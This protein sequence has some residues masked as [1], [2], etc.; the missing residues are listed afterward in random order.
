MPYN[1][2]G[3]WY[4][5]P[6][7]RKNA[8]TTQYADKDL[9]ELIPLAQQQGIGIPNA[10]PKMGLF[11]RLMN[12]LRIGETGP[13][14]QAT[15][16]GGSFL[17]EYAK[18]IGQTVSSTFTGKPYSPP[19][20]KDVLQ[21][22]LGQKQTGLP[23]K[24]LETTSGL[25]GDILG[26]PLTY[27]TLGTTGALKL[28]GKV[29]SN[30]AKPLL[31]KTA[32]EFA[33]RAGTK[34]TPEIMQAARTQWAEGL[35]QGLPEYTRHIDPGG[36]KFAGASIV[37]GETI[38]RPFKKPL[39]ILG[40][41]SIQETIKKQ[42]I[43]EAIGKTFN[44]DYGL[45]DPHVA[46]KQ[47]H[48]DEVTY[49][50]SKDF[51]QWL[52]LIKPVKA[53]DR[54]NL[55]QAIERNAI[56]SL[57][58]ELQKKAQEIR[59]FLDGFKAR[60]IQSGILKE[61]LP[62]YVPHVYK[63][64]D[65]DLILSR[66]PDRTTSSFT[67]GKPRLIGTLEEAESLGLKPEMD[68]AK[69]VG[70]YIQKFNRAESNARYLRDLGDNLGVQSTK[71]VTE[72][73][74]K[75]VDQQVLDVDQNTATHISEIYKNTQK[76]AE[77]DTELAGVQ[78][79]QRIMTGYGADREVRGFASSFPDWLPEGAR[80]KPIVDKI[81][82]HLMNGTFPSARAGNVRAGY[83]AAAKQLLSEEVPQGMRKFS[84]L[85]IAP[86][87]KIAKVDQVLEQAKQ[88]PFT[89]EE[90]AKLEA[91][92]SE[93]LVPYHDDVIGDVLLPQSVVADLTKNPRLIEDEGVRTL[94]KGYDKALN[95]WK[96]SVTSLF[97]AFHVRNASS[98]VLQN[99]LDIG[100]DA[101][102]PE[103]HSV[104]IA[105]MRM[106]DD[107][108][109]SKE[110]QALSDLGIKPPVEP[111]VLGP[112]AQTLRGTKG[113]TA[114]DIMKTHPNIKLKKDVPAKDIYGNKVVIPDGEKLT[115]YELKGNK[116]LLQDGETYIVSK[117]QFQNIKGQSVGGEPKP[118]APEL[119]GLEE[120][121]R[122]GTPTVDY[123]TY[124]NEITD[125]NQK[126]TG[127]FSGIND[128]KNS[129]KL[130]DEQLTKLKQLKEGYKTAEPKY[131]QYQLP[132]GKNYKEVLI[133]APTR[134]NSPYV[135]VKKQLGGGDYE[136]G[137]FPNNLE[138]RNEMLKLPANEYYIQPKNASADFKSSHWDEPNVISHLR[139]NERTYKGKKVTFM[140]ELQ[141]DWAREARKGQA[142]DARFPNDPYTQAHQSVPSNPLL[143]NWQ[144]PTIKRAL[145]DAVDSDAQYF[146]W[147]NGEQTSARYDLATHL[148]L[149]HWIELPGVEG[150]KG[151]LISLVEKNGE[152]IDMVITK[153]GTIAKN[154][155]KNVPEGW[156]GKKLDEVIGKGLADSIMA[157]ETGKLSG[158]GLK[159]GG[160]W[161]DNLYNKQVKN[162][163]E[164]LT[165]GKV[166]VL[167]MGLPIEKVSKEWR[168]VKTGKAPYT[169]EKLTP[170]NIK[171][172]TEVHSTI[173]SGDSY[174]ITDILGDGEF[175]AVPKD[176]AETETKYLS[177]GW[178]R[179]SKIEHA[180]QTFDISTKT[181][182][183]QGIKITPKIRA[184]VLGEALE[185][186]TSGK[187]FDE[188]PQTPKLPPELEPVLGKK[189]VEKTGQYLTTD[190]GEQIP[191]SL[192]REEAGKRQIL[193]GNF[194]I[195]DAAQTIDDQLL[196]GLRGTGKRALGLPFRAGRAVGGTIEDEARM[197]NFISNIQKGM[198]FEQAAKQTKKFLFDYQNLS[199]FEKEVMRRLVPFYT[200]VRKNISLQLEMLATRPGKV[201][202]EVKAIRNI[203]EP[204]T[205]EEKLEQLPPWAAA[206][207]GAK[208]GTDKYGRPLYMTGTGLPIEAA[209]KLGLKDLLSML[210]PAIKAPMELATGRD[211]FRGKDI[212]DV[213]KADEVAEIVN[214]TSKA[215]GVDEQE[216]RDALGITSEVKDVY[217]NNKKT[218]DK[219]T[220]YAMNPTILYL[221]RQ[222]P[223]SRLMGTVGYAAEPDVS[224]QQKLLKLLTGVKAYSFDEDEQNYFK[225]LDIKDDLQSLLKRK[226][227]IGTGTYQYEK[228]QQQ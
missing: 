195:R 1:A 80:T 172:G 135:L 109:V 206:Q 194:F 51:N 224:M 68:I 29:L 150:T 117:S 142:T 146:A 126:N 106:S 49:N 149:V 22:V 37:P 216:A 144:E 138:A 129:G 132:D 111:V 57:T 55:S 181:T 227:L 77:L 115:P 27:L 213:Y 130:T 94:L 179:E 134:E 79:G 9:R 218:G 81:K 43:V 212:K 34:I 101:I 191:Y 112:I 25:A 152:E 100:L 102:N 160:E 183:Q 63:N 62:E 221:L 141:S 180:K 90:I 98:N 61:G 71:E 6:N 85:G 163:V 228:K 139:L 41:K 3:Q 74:V 23:G 131:S 58:P 197:V 214:M 185:I 198:D 169:F 159:F 167:D 17:P 76:G 13:A 86:A 122:G 120:S 60:G 220:V 39:D 118:F 47:K 14:L 53:V 140:E 170:Q 186:K 162:I 177:N 217:V 33:E 225:E 42:P 176:I 223:T 188:V 36:I 69:S 200:W 178:T 192:I 153:D 44:R 201:A 219:E 105:I 67:H 26:D 97:P 110:L 157:E 215:F 147:I 143:K 174:I 70:A 75:K 24:A 92:M 56:E 182:T 187:Q 54:I 207:A 12:L 83:K 50:T 127:I 10:E 175:K 124:V 145:K 199:K 45:S 155:H 19:A 78:A 196:S 121:V 116:I 151:K 31:K 52:K 30:S 165:G 184:K 11:Q 72:Q 18:H 46:I 226:G 2:Q 128:L 96:G 171:V 148:D 16:Q 84:D 103:R 205:E 35:K 99:F 91:G 59:S 204:V 210:S 133:K 161:A 87:T 125:K 202:T 95:F 88:V 222:L 211:W 73:V 203:G 48:L 208:L 108:P 65:A 93:K 154:G 5:D 189:P 190:L 123:N 114:D 20:Y 40:G 168:V 158:E 15:R 136:I 8:A 66:L 166:E 64:P 28:G 156:R 82:E 89:A 104:A 7:A 193:A 137:T 164:D 4:Y 209:T 119:Q 38:A 21:D 113:L 173:G 107:A 32:L